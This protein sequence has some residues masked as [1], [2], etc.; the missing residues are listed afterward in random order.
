MEK[1]SE[2]FIGLDVAKA[3]HAVAVAEDG[4]QGEV[5]YVGEIGADTESV[6]RLVAKLEKRHGQL[7]FCYEAGPISRCTFASSCFASDRVNPR[8]VMSPRPS[9]R[10]IS[11]RSVPGSSPS[12]P[13]CTNLKIHATPPPPVR[14]QA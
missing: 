12:A 11:M 6:R 7:H 1:H 5:R 3:R 13:V 10:L 9:G 4:R 14:D 8:L 2:V